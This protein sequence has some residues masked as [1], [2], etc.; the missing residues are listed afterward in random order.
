MDRAHRWMQAS[1]GLAGLMG[2]QPEVR[3]FLREFCARCV[4][5]LGVRAAGTMLADEDGMLRVAAATD[6][7][8]ALLELLAAQRQEGPCVEGWRSGEPLYD[9]DLRASAARWPDFSSRALEHGIA[10]ASVLPLRC[11]GEQL[12]TWQ[13]YDRDSLPSRDDLELAQGLADL[14]VLC[15]SQARSLGHVNRSAAQLRA[16]LSSRIAIEQAKGMLAAQWGVH[17][18]IAFP[19]LRAYARARQRRLREVALDVV[20]GRLR[21]PPP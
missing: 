8:S 3:C 7:K 16:A 13:L 17:P 15:L 19:R 12:G 20:E 9:V 14:A 11:R 6:E 18:D 4:D 5:L 21:L 2:E 10:R 1:V